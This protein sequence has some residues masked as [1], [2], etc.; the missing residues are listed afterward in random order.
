MRS[1]HTLTLMLTIAMASPLF[2][3]VNVNAPANGASF[4]SAVPFSASSSTDCGGGVAAMGVYMDDTLI[5]VANSTTLNTSLSLPGGT[6][7]IA[8]QEWDYCGGATNSPLSVSINNQAAAGVTVTSPINNSN[9]GTSVPYSAS[10]TT[11]CPAGVASMGIYVDGTLAFQSNGSTL[12]TQLSMPAGSRN[13]TVEAWDNCGGT[14]STAVSVNVQAG[15]KLANL[16]SVGNWNQWG[17]LAPKYDICDAPC[18]GAVN[19]SMYQHQ[20]ANSLSGDSTQFNIGGGTPYSDVLWSNK[21]IGQG[22]TLNLRDEDKKI[23]PSVKHLI[24]DTDIFMGNFAVAQ[25]LEFDV[26]LFMSGV[27]ME[28]GMECNHLDGN[29]WDIWNNI[30]AHWVHTTIPCA[31]NDQQWNHVHFE[32]QRESNNDLTYLSI[33]VNGVTSPINVTVAPFA[34]SKHWYGMTVNY[35]MDGNSKQAPYMTMIDNMS[36]TYW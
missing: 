10:A 4:N 35:Q 14:Q 29:V 12:Q 15:N 22:S 31:I 8:V 19:W 30:D 16:Q 3:S 23:L 11:S 1:F 28:W 7:R 20:S 18:S 25:D 6:H 27:G 26:N 13:T 2:A 9:V 32:V 21:L 34:V 17:E 33:T 36:V 5:Y 24:Y